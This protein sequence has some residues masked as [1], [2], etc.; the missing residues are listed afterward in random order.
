MIGYHIT[1]YHVTMSSIAL[2]RSRVQMLLR[3]KVSLERVS[4]IIIYPVSN[5]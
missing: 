4:F 1:L 5:P 2:R 3:H